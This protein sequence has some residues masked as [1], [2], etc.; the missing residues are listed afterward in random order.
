[1]TRKV[2]ICC[3]SKQVNIEFNRS[4]EQAVVYLEISG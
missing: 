2:N 1:M 3:T 4:T